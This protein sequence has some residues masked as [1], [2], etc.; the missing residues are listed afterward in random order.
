MPIKPRYRLRAGWHTAGGD[1]AEQCGQPPFANCYCGGHYI[2]AG[3]DKSANPYQRKGRK[4]R[5]CQGQRGA[6][7]TDTHH[8]QTAP[9]GKDGQTVGSGYKTP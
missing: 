9:A 5:S 1:C 6:A 7:G 4:L 8:R 2:K 3:Q